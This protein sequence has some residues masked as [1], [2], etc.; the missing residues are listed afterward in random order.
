MILWEHPHG[1][2]PDVRDIITWRAVGRE[3]TVNVAQTKAVKSLFCDTAF[4]E[5]T[6]GIGL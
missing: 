5:R 6:G 4:L 2:A 3:P 1:S